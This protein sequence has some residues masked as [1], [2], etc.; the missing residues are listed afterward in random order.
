MLYF[1]WLKDSRCLNSNIHKKL[2]YREA[3]VIVIGNCNKESRCL[4]LTFIKN[5]NYREENVILMGRNTRRKLVGVAQIGI[6]IASAAWDV[7]IWFFNLY[8]IPPTKPRTVT[9]GSP[10]RIIRWRRFQVWFEKSRVIMA[11]PEEQKGVEARSITITTLTR[12]QK[13]LRDSDNGGSYLGWKK[14]KLK[15]FYLIRKSSRKISKRNMFDKYFN[16]ISK[17]C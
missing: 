13:C 3:K 2:N 11:S 8:R 15:T 9:W 16:Q 5:L 17:V 14:T 1:Y 4:N 7:K 12:K 10:D 6:W